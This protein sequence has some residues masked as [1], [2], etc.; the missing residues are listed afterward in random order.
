[1]LRQS[2]VFWPGVLPVL[3]LAVAGWGSGA[4]S[5]CA[6]NPIAVATTPDQKA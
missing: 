6:S 3:L 5:G 2:K 1:M 4:L